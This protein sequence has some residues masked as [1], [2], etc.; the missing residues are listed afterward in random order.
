MMARWNDG[1]MGRWDDETMIG[2]S[3]QSLFQIQRRSLR[4]S[5]TRRDPK[6]I[7]CVVPQRNNTNAKAPPRR[8]SA[9]Y[10]R[11]SAVAV[12][13][14][15]HF[16]SCLHHFFR[17]FILFSAYNSLSFSLPFRTRSHLYF[18]YL[19]ASQTF[20]TLNYEAS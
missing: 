9:P 8:Y 15:F 7:L 19:R 17:S 6:L 18:F 13:P 12:W 4:T 20:I 1:T 16:H 14:G 2:S 10:Y 5:I 3:Q 11:P